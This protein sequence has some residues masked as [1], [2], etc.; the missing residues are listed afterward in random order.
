[1]P[2]FYYRVGANVFNDT[3]LPE[4]GHIEDKALF[5]RTSKRYK[6]NLQELA[7]QVLYVSLCLLMYYHVC[8]MFSYLTLCLLISSYISLS[9]RSYLNPCTPE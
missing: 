7:N 4:H 6:T 3:D 1:M 2:D 9:S 8:L 5:K